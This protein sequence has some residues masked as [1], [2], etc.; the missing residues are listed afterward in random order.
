[1]YSNSF[2]FNYKGVYIHGATHGDTQI[3]KTQIGYEIKTHRTL[4]GA[5]AYV[6]RMVM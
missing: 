4:V 2:T 6:T 1:M 3:F 5:K